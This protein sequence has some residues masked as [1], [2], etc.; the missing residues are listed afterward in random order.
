MGKATYSNPWHRDGA[1]NGS[2]PAAY[3]TSAKPT[4]Y[5][6]F[7]VYERVKGHVWDV[8]RDGACVTQRAGLNGAREAIDAM[9]PPPS[10][11]ARFAQTLA[12]PDVARKDGGR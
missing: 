4:E 8:V 9:S 12:F 5:R 1:R 10:S 6:G 11:L 7:L 3:E 2:G